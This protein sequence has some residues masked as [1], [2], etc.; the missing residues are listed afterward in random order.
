VRPLSQQTLTRS[1]HWRE[2][3]FLFADSVSESGQVGVSVFILLMNLAFGVWAICA[4]L[5]F[6]FFMRKAEEAAAAKE[7]A[8]AELYMSTDLD[9]TPTMVRVA[10]RLLTPDALLLCQSQRATPAL[11]PRP[12]AGKHRMSTVPPAGAPRSHQ[13]TVQ[14]ARQ[15]AGSAR[16]SE[17][18]QTPRLAGFASTA[19]AADASKEAKKVANARVR[20]AKR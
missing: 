8:R 7:A 14:A 18:G 17:T 9:F 15:R 11:L 5:W 6:K 16:T 19:A 13:R 2:S 1:M 3:Q 10:R 4:W 12:A 20:A